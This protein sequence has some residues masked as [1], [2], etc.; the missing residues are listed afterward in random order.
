MG[1]ATPLRSPDAA[2]A[3]A[4]PGSSRTLVPRSVS[5]VRPV[6]RPAAG[7]PTS[8]AVLEPSLVETL[9]LLVDAARSAGALAL[10]FLVPGLVLG[11][12][13]APG[14]MSPLARLGRAAGVSLLTASAACTVLAL[15]GLLRP[16]VVV[17]VLA[18]VTLAPLAIRRP[19]LHGPTRRARR[20]WL[21]AGL[22]SLVFLGLIVAPSA[23]EVGPSLLP[24]TSTVWYYGGLSDHVAALGAVPATYPE[25]GT[26]R[27]FHTDYLPFT[28]HAAAA[29]QLLPGDLTVRMELYRLALLVAAGLVAALLL[30]R[31]VPTWLAVLGAILLLATDRLAFKFLAFKPET[32]GIV[33]A[34]F[35]LWA[36][37]RALV[38]R[39]RRL[40][41]LALLT[42]TLTFLAHAEVF[43]VLAA[44]VAGLALARLVVAPAR[45]RATPANV[46]DAVGLRLPRPRRVALVGGLAAVV[47][48]GSLVAGAL[49]NGLFAGEFRLIGYVT[50]ERGDPPA[51]PAVPPA[52]APPGWSYTGD[53]TWDFYV[54]AVAPNQLGEEPPSVF[55]GRRLLP[56][57][58]L[59]IWS[60]LDGR[61]PSL[62]IVLGGLL[63]LPLLA[64]PWLD[65]RRRRLVLAGYAFGVVLAVGAWLLFVIS[66]TYVPRRVGPRRLMPFELVVPVVAA[67]TV[68][69]GVDRLLR[70]GW[71]ALLPSG[72]G[73]GRRVARTAAAG[74]LLALLTAGM[75]A[76]TPE[77]AS[78]EVE[79]RITE[80]GAE[81]WRWI[82]RETPADARILVNAYTDGVATALGE[83]VGILDGRAVYL[84]DREFLTASTEALLG[85]RGLFLDPGGDAAGAYLDRHAVDY[86]LVTDRTRG[87]VGLDVGGYLPFET[88]L[89]SLEAAGRYTLVRT[90]GD[91]RIRLYEVARGPS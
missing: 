56:R 42:A 75:V 83:R 12:H 14:A 55:T 52:D 27:P 87:G 15:I 5:P 23:A 57:S 46:G 80:A 20:W 71:R 18:A 59:H 79:G 9:D 81:A 61:S 88:D 89:A 73:A 82:A 91:G 68:L 29:F 72:G 28:A 64:W 17:A 41:V 74:G 25:W 50:G 22:A 21:G 84:E 58:I 30:R 53:P 34:L 4:P 76:P 51:A 19:R 16:P 90:F 7:G 36:F 31:A 33:V 8:R 77:L 10:L 11:A 48:G 85:A 62:L 60:G 26:L 67:L 39:S 70:P 69:W 37:D 38:E 3:R 65:A 32:F 13:L 40:A 54:A 6:A 49:V 24:Y 44:A 1:A 45:G 47:L 66:D 78:E 2:R 35:A 43:L 86:V 63:A